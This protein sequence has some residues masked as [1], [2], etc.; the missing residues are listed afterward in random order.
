MKNNIPRVGSI[1]WA[2]KEYF[3]G[4]RPTIVISE[5]FEQYEE[6]WIS[7]TTDPNK[8]QNVTGGTNSLAFFLT[9][10]ERVR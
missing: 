2:K 5:T 9:C 10:Y 8:N 4:T 6:I 1:W 3:H 7:F